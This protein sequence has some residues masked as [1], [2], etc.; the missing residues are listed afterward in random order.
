GTC[1]LNSSSFTFF[2]F[3]SSCSSSRVVIRLCSSFLSSMHHNPLYGINSHFTQGFK[4]TFRFF[5]RFAVNR[6]IY[7]HGSKYCEYQQLVQSAI[8]DCWNDHTEEKRSKTE[9]GFEH[10]EKGRCCE[11]HVFFLRNIYTDSL[12]HGLEVAEPET[13]QKPRKQQHYARF[14]LSHYE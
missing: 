7:D 2:F 14:S 5:L 4:L 6:V 13:D 1:S 12:S 8:T 3:F 9:P 10:Y 11:P